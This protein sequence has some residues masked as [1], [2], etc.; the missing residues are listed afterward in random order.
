MAP[1]DKK[2][3]AALLEAVHGVFKSNKDDLTVNFIRKRVESELELE[4]GFFS[5]GKWKDKSKK[6]IK[7]LAVITPPNPG[8]RASSL[9]DPA[10]L[11]T[12]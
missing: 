7:E 11:T 5:S 8:T 4:D 9:L 3:Q 12:T 2:I 6:L 1:S 10:Q